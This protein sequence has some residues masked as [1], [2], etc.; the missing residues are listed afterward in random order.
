MT[1]FDD[2]KSCVAA[3]KSFVLQ[4]GAGSGKTETLKQT[5]EFISKNERKKIICITHTNLAADEIKSRVEGDHVIST[6]HS[7]L[8]HFTKDYKRNL[9]KIIHH[10]FVIAAIERQ[11]LEEYGGDE[12]LQNKKE[13]EKYKKAYNKYASSLFLVKNEHM[14]K[15][16]GKREYDKNPEEYNDLLNQKIHA[17]NEEIIQIIS[18]RNPSKIEYNETQFNNFS[19]LSYGHDG[20]LELSYL[21]FERY[22]LIRKILQDKFDFVFIDEYQDANE[23]I[24]DIFLRYFLN[25]EENLVG[26]FGDSMQA[27]YEDGIGDVKKYVEDGT[28]IKINKEDNYRCSEQVKDFINKLR[29]D[30]LTQDIAFKKKEDGTY[31]TLADRQGSVSLYYCVYGEKPHARS[32]EDDKNSYAEKLNGLITKAAE[33]EDN[34]VQLKLTNKSIASDVGFEALYLIFSNR[35]LEAQEYMGRHLRQLQFAELFEL[36]NA[37]NPPEGNLP[38][39]NYVISQLKHRGFSIKRVSDKQDAKDKFD[40]ILNSN[41]GAI[42]AL[43]KAFNLNLIKKSDGYISYLERRE[44]F[45]ESTNANEPYLNFKQLYLNG[46]NTLTRIKGDLPDLEEEDF[47]ELERDVKKEEF[48]EGLFSENLKFQEIINY[49][50]YLNE[51][52]QYITMHKTKGGEKENIIVVLDEYY[53]R[54]YDFKSVFSD[55]GDLDKRIKNQKLVYVACSRAKKNLKCIRIVSDENEEAEMKKY[56]DNTVKVQ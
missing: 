25:P 12:S 18:E 53:W 41:L 50:R 34:Y 14:P 45:L 27:I 56:F 16:E 38:N 19:E 36:C 37:Y 28:L 10:L 49:Y 13:H 44:G 1:A 9:H 33:G 32:A 5:L 46:K 48:Y 43:N 6:I 54:D 39:Y 2:I 42:E 21:L 51:D 47:K 8:N 35:Y 55:D 40:M 22:P 11:G 7:F 31:E 24:I 3:N 4:G 26:L 15:V 29:N 30:D 20:L 52:T 17:L 23:K